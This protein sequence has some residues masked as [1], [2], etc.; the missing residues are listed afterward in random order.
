[1]KCLKLICFWNLSWCLLLSP[2]WRKELR[3]LYMFYFNSF[4]LFIYV[5]IF[6]PEII[7][8]LSSLNDLWL[9]NNRI[10]RLPLE[11]GQLLHLS[12]LDVSKNRLVEIDSEVGNC[13]ALSHLYLTRNNLEVCL[14]LYFFA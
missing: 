14:F 6:Q 9:D 13:K 2:I 4:D 11:I 10:K 12:F 1:M 7:G 8:H 5:Y 3:F